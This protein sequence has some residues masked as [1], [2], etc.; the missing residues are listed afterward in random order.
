[1]L[2]NTSSTH[3]IPG[4]REIAPDHQEMG[5]P[6]AE[7]I[8]HPQLQF[9][10]KP[11]ASKDIKYDLHNQQDYG[12]FED[13]TTKTI[14]DKYALVEYYHPTSHV[15]SRGWFRSMSTSTQCCKLKSRP[16]PCTRSFCSQKRHLDV[17]KTITKTPSTILA[18]KLC[19]RFVPESYAKHSAR[20]LQRIQ[21]P[22]SPQICPPEEM[23]KTRVSLKLLKSKRFKQHG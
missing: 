1:M 4:G 21:V 15:C 23:M 19:E 16:Q 17:I 20:L 8:V 13:F 12:K 9:F 5:Q 18:G 10:H 11:A 3:Q 6:C 14:A 2:T 22:W 7:S